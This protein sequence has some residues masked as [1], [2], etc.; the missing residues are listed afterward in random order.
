MKNFIEKNRKPIFYLI[1]I[2]SFL[3]A[4]AY[5]FLT[6][7]LSDDIFYLCQ[8][9]NASSYADVVRYN[10][11]E[12]ISNNCRFID[13]LLMRTF[14]WLGS[15]NYANIINSLVFTLLGLLIYKNAGTK[16]KYD[17]GVIILVFLVLWYCAVDFGDT[18]LWI[19]GASSYLY[20]ITWILGFITLYRSMLNKAS[21]KHPVLCNI[22]LFLLGIAAGMSNE[23]TSGGCFL[24]I[25]MFTLNKILNNKKHG[26]SF[27]DS[28]KHYML[29]GHIAVLAGLCL[30]VSGP[31]S[32]SR[33]EVVDQGNYSGIVG[34][35]SHIYKITLDLHEVLL[36]LLIMLIAALV[37]LV[38]QKRFKSFYE[39]RNDAGI[40]FLLSAVIT[41]YVMAVIEPTT[42]RVYFGASIFMITA[43]IH[44]VEEIKYDESI[45]RVMRF[46]LISLLCLWFFFTYL[47]NLVNLARIYREEN[48][49]TELLL[50]AKE[51][52]HSQDIVI[53]QYRPDWDNRYTTAYRNDMER[54]PGYWINV[55]YEEYYGIN[56]IYAVP[57]EE[58][59]ELYSEKYWLGD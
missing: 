18:I 28:I 23:N 39:V 6:P 26:I 36:P 33:K 49:R 51:E 54:D 58:W 22:A 56:G 27:K 25:F 20:G 15:K 17:I 14:L 34:I 1:L 44:F 45:Y 10:Y 55:F 8:V 46:L 2:C 59:E 7:Y 5:N 32:G 31:G 40:V 21:F 13:Q 47:D 35:L 24:I 50:R 52:G 48:E 53:P 12:Y 19:A 37:I 4:G 9:R 43:F 29:T 30:L 38:I 57:R 41:I 11:G 3:C 42:H 16:K